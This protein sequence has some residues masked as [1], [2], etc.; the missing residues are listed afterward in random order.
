MVSGGGHL[1]M[2][3]FFFM[4][5]NSVEKIKIDTGSSGVEHPIFKR[6][7]VASF[8]D[9]SLHSDDLKKVAVTAS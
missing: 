5:L 3:S 7:S 4:R 9:R 8:S 1:A 6:W 2:E